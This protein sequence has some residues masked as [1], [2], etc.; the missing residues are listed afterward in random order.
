[1]CGI[2]FLSS[3]RFQFGFEKTAGSVLKNRWFSFLCRSVVKYKKRVSCLTCVCTLV[4]GFLNT[5]LVLTDN[6]IS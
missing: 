6:L 5:Q 4:D 3:V 2:D 1:M